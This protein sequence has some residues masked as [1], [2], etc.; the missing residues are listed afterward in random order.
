MGA[1]MIG[2]LADWLAAASAVMLVMLVV[3]PLLVTAMLFLAWC[4]RRKWR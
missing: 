3:A 4:R 1:T 2:V